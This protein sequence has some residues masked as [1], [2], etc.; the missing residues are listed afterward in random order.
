MNGILWKIKQNYAAYHKIAVTLLV[1]YTYKMNIFGCFA[2]CVHVS[3]YRS[4][5]D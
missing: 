1:T 4:L 5:K 3:E 2:M